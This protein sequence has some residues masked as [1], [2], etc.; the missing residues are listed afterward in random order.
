MLFD[1]CINDAAADWHHE[2]LVCTGDEYIQF[3]LLMS[4]VKVISDFSTLKSI[5]I[6]DDMED[7]VLLAYL[8]NVDDFV[9]CA[10]SE[11]AC[12]AE[13]AQDLLGCHSFN[14]SINLS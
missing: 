8:G 4:L 3:A 6:I 2:V 7:I 10:W 14:C 5:S 9:R 13:D 11:A 12:R 1:R